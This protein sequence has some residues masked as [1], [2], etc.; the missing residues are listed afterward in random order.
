MDY[1][2]R[3]KELNEYLPYFPVDGASSTGATTPRVFK[4]YRGLH[5]TIYGTEVKTFCLLL[6]L[7]IACLNQIIDIENNKPI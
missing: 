5:A 2:L 4:I 3:L 7:K 6:L 1:W